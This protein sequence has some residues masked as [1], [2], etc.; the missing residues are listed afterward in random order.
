MGAVGVLRC[1]RGKRRGTHVGWLFLGF[2]GLV[3][4]RAVFFSGLNLDNIGNTLLVYIVARY[5]D[6]R[7]LVENKYTPHSRSFSI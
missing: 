1:T 5:P 4:V 7:I 6:W 3:I 2:L